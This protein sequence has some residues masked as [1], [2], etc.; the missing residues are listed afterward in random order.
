MAAARELDYTAEADLG[1]V[2]AAEMVVAASLAT[3][4]EYQDWGAVESAAVV[5]HMAVAADAV[6]VAKGTED[7]VVVAAVEAEMMEVVEGIADCSAA[8]VVGMM[9][10]VELVGKNLTDYQ[11]ETI[12]FQIL[13]C[14]SLKLRKFTVFHNNRKLTI[15][16]QNSEQVASILDDIEF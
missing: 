1:A 8:S 16:P 2:V 11:L 10:E 6:A 3:V 14:S 15:L 12:L 4:V 5:A 9:E 13:A 7:S